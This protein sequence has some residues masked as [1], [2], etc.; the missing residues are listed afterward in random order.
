MNQ[1]INIHQIVLPINFKNIIPEDDSKR[2]LYDVTE[3]L[4]YKKLYK[5]YSSMNRNSAILPETLFRIIV[6]G[7]MK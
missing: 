1:I 5:S 7:Y 3:G 2:L 6:Y 4:N